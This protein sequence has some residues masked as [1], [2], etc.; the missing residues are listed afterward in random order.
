MLCAARRP[1]SRKG[2][3]LST[4]GPV[5]APLFD[6]SGGTIMS[7]LRIVMMVALVVVVSAGIAS[8]AAEGLNQT[9]KPDLKSIGPIAFGPDGVLFVGDPMGAT[10]YAIGVDAASG[11]PGA[12]IK[13]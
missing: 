2:L 6:S 1:R 7:R 12:G 8:A 9:G 10:L 3:I 5:T 11:S 4:S 13:V